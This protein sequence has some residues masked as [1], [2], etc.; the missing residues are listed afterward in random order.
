MGRLHVAQ[1]TRNLA[2]T[3]LSP[4]NPIEVYSRTNGLE[5]FQGYIGDLAKS[6]PRL[7]IAAIEVLASAA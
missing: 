2:A 5:M 1:S 7:A 3:D 4:S 6:E